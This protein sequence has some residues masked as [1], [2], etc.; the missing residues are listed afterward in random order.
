MKKPI[1]ALHSQDTVQ[2]KNNGMVNIKVYFNRDSERYTVEY[3]P[4][5]WNNNRYLKF[6]KGAKNL[7]TLMENFLKEI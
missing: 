6:G 3:N 1:I 7:T 2:S 4:V 5:S